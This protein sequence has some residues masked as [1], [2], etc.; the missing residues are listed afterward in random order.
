MK[1][2]LEKLVQWSAPKRVK[3][4]QGDRM[5]RT[6]QVTP[7]FWDAWK[8]GKD[9]LKKAGVSV[10]RDDRSGDWTAVW[11][12]PLD[13][14]TVAREQ[15]SIEASKAVD[16]EIDV[17][18]PDGLA[19]LP[20][21]RG[22]IKFMIERSG[23]LLGDEMGLGKSVQS[24][25]VINADSTIQSVLVV[26]PA[27][28]KLNWRNELKRWLVRKLSVGVQYGGVGWIGNA[29]DVV[30]INYELVGKH[31]AIHEREWDLL[32]VDEAHFMKNP[33]AQRTQLVLGCRKWKDREACPGI[34][35]R[36]R[37]FLTG[38]PILNKPV[39]I[40][41]LLESLQPGQWTFKDKI[42]Y[43]SGFQGAWG[44]DFSGASN[45]EELQRRLRSSV[46]LR[47][48]KREVLKD[49]PKIRRQLIELSANGDS[50]LV[51][52]ERDTYDRHEDK[53]CRLRARM[54]CADTDG[55]YQ[56]A[57]D[58]LKKAQ[59]AAF[60]EIARM[61]HDVALAKLPKVIEHVRG[62][63]EDG[64]GKVVIFAHH[65]DC[66]HRL[67]EEFGI[68]C[69]AVTGETPQEHRQKIIDAF[70]ADKNI[71][72]LL[73]A[74]HAAGVGLSVKASVEVFAEL[75]W[76]PAVISQAEGRCNGI[77]RGI[78]GEPLLVQH[79]VL[80]GSLDARMVQAIIAKQEIADRALDKD[81][82][83]QEAGVAVTTVEIG[84]VI[85]EQS[86]PEAPPPTAAEIEKAHEGLRVLAGLC[87][88]A[89]KL[90]GAGFNRL[91]VAIG[92]ELASRP[93][94]SL[95]QGELSLRIVRKYKTQ[96]LRAGCSSTTTTRRSA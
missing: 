63:L 79:L 4:R 25:G 2:E 8:A 22:G 95:R 46:M 84:S 33:K 92:H 6:A 39:E 37:L 50:A 72:V 48:L 71:T 16:A 77:G 78:E 58:G 52:A 61:R 51:E 53:L 60:A 36:R 54:A 82:P 83:S 56:A 49:L 28:L 40:F 66:H 15:A 59:S 20:F 74:I 88:G 12:M 34:R 27:T 30:V 68:A 23:T 26:C 70:N 1:V 21:Q 91:D 5:L 44:W 13:G 57:A 11:W 31:D 93:R 3:T 69:L 94:L 45:L 96:L 90:D 38:T 81:A 47:R 24:I 43:C 62:V 67:K 9:E 29:V 18:V 76:V 64:A 87:D 65:M 7:E 42:R 17:P 35:A 89:Q 85:Q 86:K 41:P 80:E 10:S 75:D 19:Y 32:I 55:E 73:L 14:A